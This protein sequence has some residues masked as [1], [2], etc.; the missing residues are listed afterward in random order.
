LF[1]WGDFSND[2]VYCPVETQ[3]LREDITEAS[4]EAAIQHL[5]IDSE[6]K[7]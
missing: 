1:V 2:D 5:V 7:V 3:M 6:E 4:L